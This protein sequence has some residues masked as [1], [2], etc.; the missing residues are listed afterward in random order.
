MTTNIFQEDNERR[1][2]PLSF[3]GDTERELTET[4]D[5]RG[6]PESGKLTV[7]IAPPLPPSARANIQ[8]LP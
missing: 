2:E 1:L 4:R 7:F 5:A 8:T 3:L 6:G